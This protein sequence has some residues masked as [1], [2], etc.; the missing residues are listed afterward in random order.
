MIGIKVSRVIAVAVL[1]LVTVLCPCLFTESAYGEPEESVQQLQN[2]LK[3]VREEL[4]QM[5]EDNSERLDEIEDELADISE[6]KGA[7]HTF[8]DTALTFGGFATTLVTSIADSKGRETSFEHVRFSLLF[9]ADL[10]EDWSMFAD[11]LAWPPA[12]L[13]VS[14]SGVF[15]QAK[16]SENIKCPSLAIGLRPKI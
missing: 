12:I 10:A 2:D 15:G 3:Q 4:K 13:G 14:T 9:H 8:G 11:S 7:V 1:A 5:K 16:E 6:L